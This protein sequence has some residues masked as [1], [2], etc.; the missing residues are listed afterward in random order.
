MSN[1]TLA[2]DKSLGSR[3]MGRLVERDL[4]ILV[5]SQVKSQFTEVVNLSFILLGSYLKNNIDI[6]ELFSDMVSFQ[7]MYEAVGETSAPSTLQF[8]AW[9]LYIF[10]GRYF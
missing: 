8:M 3:L 2:R 6:T 1:Q 5:Q 10:T 9:S 7:S 4:V